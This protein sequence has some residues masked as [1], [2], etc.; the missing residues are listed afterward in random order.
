M[1]IVGKKLSLCDYKHLGHLH[2]L[3]LQCSL[4]TADGQAEGR[5]DTA[6]QKANTSLLSI[7]HG[8]KRS[9]CHLQGSSGAEE[10]P[11]ETQCL[12]RLKRR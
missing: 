3:I 12:Q 2:L 4:L 10:C 7:F 8:K 9:Q 5:D 1:F 11:V 6:P